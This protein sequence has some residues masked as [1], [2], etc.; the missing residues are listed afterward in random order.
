[1]LSKNNG[2]EQKFGKPVDR[3]S[4]TEF[5]KYIMSEAVEQYG[6]GN[7][8]DI[9]SQNIGDAFDLS[10]TRVYKVLKDGSEVVDVMYSTR[11]GQVVVDVE[12]RNCPEFR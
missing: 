5:E 6:P 12:K 3:M 10:A 1:M 11:N 2:L 9:T 4:F 7:Y 8:T